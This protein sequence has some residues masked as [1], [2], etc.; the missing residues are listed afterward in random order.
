M[1][2]VTSGARLAYTFDLANV[3]D[4]DAAG[5]FVVRAYLSRDR[6]V[7]AGDLQDGVVETG[8]FAAGD[9]S[10]AVL[11]NFRSNAYDQPEFAGGLELGYGGLAYARAGVNV[12]PDQDQNANEFWSIGGGLRLP[13]SNSGIAVDYA[14]RQMG[15]LG[16]QNLITASLTF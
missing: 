6:V 10:V 14:F 11:G 3:G 5:D 2:T 13:L 8:N 15:D 12:M 7:D 16:D 4:G 1:S 9:V